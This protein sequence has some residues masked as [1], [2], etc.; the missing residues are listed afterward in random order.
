MPW[1]NARPRRV[2]YDAG[3]NR[4][5]TRARAALRAAGTGTCAEPEC[6]MPSRVI[7]PDMD[8]HLS[9]DPTGRIVIGLSHRICN[10][11][12]AAKRARALQDATRLTW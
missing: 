3:H 5:A 6:V 2:K 9:H 1:D 8:L 12:E 4:M 10:V 7:T 11:T